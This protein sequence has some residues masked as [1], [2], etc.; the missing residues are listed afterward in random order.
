MTKDNSSMDQ[1][2]NI[3]VSFIVPLHRLSTGTFSG[4]MA[5]VSNVV[6]SFVMRLRVK[7]QE[8]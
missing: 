8:T 2:E 4:V 6:Q 7:D 3:I 5:I 1:N